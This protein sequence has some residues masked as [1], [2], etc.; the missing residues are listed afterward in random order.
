VAASGQAFGEP[1][2][3][4]ILAGR[5]GAGEDHELGHGSNLPGGRQVRQTEHVPAVKPC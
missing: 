1:V 2:G 4:R 3:D 5:D